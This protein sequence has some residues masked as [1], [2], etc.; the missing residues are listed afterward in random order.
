MCLQFQNQKMVEAYTTFSI[1]LITID[2]GCI[3]L[4]IGEMALEWTPT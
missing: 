4:K 3:E 1:C 2:K